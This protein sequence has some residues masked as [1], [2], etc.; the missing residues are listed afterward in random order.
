MSTNAA[1]IALQDGKTRA[2]TVAIESK[3]F[4]H[5]AYVAKYLIM[6]NFITGVENVNIED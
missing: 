2:N 6:E 1:L 3:V 5:A 4:R